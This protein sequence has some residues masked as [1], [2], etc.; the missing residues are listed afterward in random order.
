M[1]FASAIL[2]R[3]F[4]FIAD[5]HD[6]PRTDRLKLKNLYMFTRPPF[7]IKASTL[8]LLGLAAV[9]TVVQAC[10]TPDF[11][12]PDP[13]SGDVAAE[14]TPQQR[15]GTP[16]VSSP[17][18]NAQ[19]HQPVE[20]VKVGE[21]QFEIPGIGRSSNA[22][23]STNTRPPRPK[24]ST[25][26]AA[27]KE[28]TLPDFIDTVFGQMLQVPYVTGPGVADR[29]D[30]IIKLRTSGELAS[31]DFLEL[32]IDALKEYGVAV[33]PE[34][35]VYKLLDD[36]ALRARIPLFI[37]ARS[38]PDTPGVLRPLVMFRELDAVASADMESILKQAFPDKKR[39]KISSNPRINVVTLSGLPDDVAA[40]VRIIDQMDELSYA[41][42][43]LVRYSPDYIP[44]KELSDQLAQML[45]IEGWQ[46]SS[47]PSV[48][49]TVVVVPVEFTNDLFIFSKSAEALARSRFWL[50]KLDEPAKVG[51]APQLFVYAVKNVDATILS[52][53]VNAVLMGGQGRRSAGSTSAGLAGV[54]GLAQAPVP[55][56]QGATGLND[57]SGTLVVDP[58]SNRLIYSGTASDYRRLL[59][60]LEQLDRPPGEVLIQVTIAEITLTDETRYGLEFFVDSVGDANFTGTVGNQGLGVGS[61]GLNIGIFSGNVEMAL[62]AMAKNEKVNVLSKPKLVARSGGTARLQVGTDVPVI[63]SQR[64]AS[65]QDGVGQTDILQQVEYRKTGIL[66]SIEPIIFSDNRVDLTIS[67]EVST[68]L[69]SAGSAIASPTISNR[70]LD[71]QL[72]IQDG[73]TIVLGGLIQNTTTESET[74]IPL[75]KDLPIA[76]NLFRNNAI[77]QTR[78]ELL[79]LITAYI[80]Q[81]TND[82]SGFTD[83]LILDLENSASRSD[84]MTTLLRPRP[85]TVNPPRYNQF[86]E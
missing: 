19:E 32:V 61:D 10:S 68:A 75:L 14:S 22:G 73:E 67:Q 24:T 81:D 34:D 9:L 46:A 79:I 41:G 47:N 65:S 42:T 71:T 51:D 64:A 23:G 49:R 27:V 21:K 78:T 48:R 6:F 53:T 20:G 16:S 8:S 84:N 13:M 15:L 18:L 3:I 12:R 30:V 7:K 50:D 70:N 80:L 26:D 82:K 57:L 55:A 31:A 2:D 62:N 45:S 76:G 56:Q 4:S 37:R 11:R 25:I 33:V 36:A 28:L 58:M 66:L 77:S 39:L 69:P 5:Q 54:N 52:T 44:A 1:T 40:A 29:N 86:G 59:P 83:Q 17:T 63:T 60:L 85:S 43:Q 35:G 38:T 74:G 72:S